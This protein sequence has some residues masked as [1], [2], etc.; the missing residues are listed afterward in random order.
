MPR[1]RSDQDASAA[2][3]SERSAV[4]IS[5]NTHDIVNDH[6]GTAEAEQIAS[7]TP[8]SGYIPVAAGAGNPAAWAAMPESGGL[9]DL[10]TGNDATF[11]ASL[12]S[13]TNS[14]GTMTRDTAYK[15]ATR[16]ASLKFAVTTTGQ[17]VD[18]AIS[19]TFKAG[20]SYWAVFFLSNESTTGTYN[21]NLSLG[22]IGTDAA[23]EGISISPVTGLPYVG[24]GN[25][26]AYGINWVPTADRTGVS[27]RLAVTNTATTTWHI[28]MMR[29]WETP[30]LAPVK[31]GR[32][33]SPMNTEGILLASPYGTSGLEFFLSGALQLMVTNN[34]GGVYISHNSYMNIWTDHTAGDKTTD[35]INFSVGEDYLGFFI[36]QKD[37]TTVQFYA[38]WDDYSFEFED[39]AANGWGSVDAS[40]VLRRFSTMESRKGSGTATITSTNTSVSVTHGAGYTPSSSDITVTPTNNPTNDPGWF[41]ISS[42]GATTFDI[43]VRSDP[44]ASGATFAWRVDR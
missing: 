9:L 23:T 39:G 5:R 40:G 35:G 17:Y 4:A 16:T 44:G 28:G 18:L 41:W 37:A 34:L 8:T 26:I 31:A 13:W 20:R 19:G 1:M 22:A 2:C 24:D 11:D 30:I 15:M 43:N 3:R 36:G 12:G 38:D 29:V 7:G 27:V 21:I 33:Y 25:F 10:V 14:G 32:T 42:I 6:F